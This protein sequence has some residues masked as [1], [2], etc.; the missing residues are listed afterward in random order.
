[1][2]VLFPLLK[3]YIKQYLGATNITVAAIIVVLSYMNSTKGNC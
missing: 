3:K 2:G 1:M